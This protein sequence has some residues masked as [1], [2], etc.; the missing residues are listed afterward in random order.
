MVSNIYKTFRALLNIINANWKRIK[1]PSEGLEK[2]ENPKEVAS[3]R[4]AAPALVAANSSM[5]PFCAL[6]NPPK[7]L[8]VSARTYKSSGETEER[9]IN[10]HL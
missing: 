1:F 4:K 5:N 10:V 9:E 6:P 8:V 2:T 3:P 7:K